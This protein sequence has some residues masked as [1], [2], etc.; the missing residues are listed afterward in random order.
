MYK[1]PTG[2]TSKLIT[3]GIADPGVDAKTS[4]EFDFAAGVAMFGMLLRGSK[5]KGTSSYTLAGELARGGSGTD[6]HG[7][8][9][10]FLAL[11][12]RAGELSAPAAAGTR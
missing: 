6:P 3:R 7:Y 2:A 8:R 10:E 9:K 5:F 1:K 11:V 12:Q 4:H